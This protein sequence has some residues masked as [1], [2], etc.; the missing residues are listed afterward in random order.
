MRLSN[1]LNW[2]R[3]DKAVTSTE[4]A[5]MLALILG[6]CTSAINC[7]GLAANNTFQNVGNSIEQSNG[8]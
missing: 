7:L 2:L 1:I 5:V 6:I 3:D 4:Y 8:S